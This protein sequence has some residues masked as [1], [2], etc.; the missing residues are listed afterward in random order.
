MNDL[1][2]EIEDNKEYLSTTDGDEIE[3]ISIEIL[4][5]ILEKYNI[6]ES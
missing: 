1:L 4:K 2:I 5:G 3:C 6:M